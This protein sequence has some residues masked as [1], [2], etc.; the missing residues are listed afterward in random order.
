MPIFMDR[1][2]VHGVTAESVAAAHQEDL[3]VQSEYDCKA[4]TYW[5]DQARGTAFCL[6]E[7]PTAE[8]VKELHRHAHGLVPH[9]I[10]EVKTTE[11]LSFLGRVS[12]PE[13]ASDEPLHEPAFRVIMFTDMANS[14]AITQEL[15]DEAAFELLQ[16]HHQVVRGA[17]AAHRG[18]ELDK[19]GDGFLASFS[20]V[21]S[22]IKCAVAIQQALDTHNMDASDTPIQVRIGL[23]AGEPIADGPALFGSVINQTARICA[24][25]QPGQILVS[26][27]VRDL[28]VGK[29]IAFRPVGQLDIKGFS[30]PVEVE[31]VRWR[32]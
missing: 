30:E 2:D 1:H 14:T 5:F 3:R 12:D 7:A 31:E 10:I 22:A 11:V 18:R 21:G 32:E 6:F 26:R 28:C 25:A 20:S 13:S 15:G 9:D 8:A 16:R 27:V 4:L 24:Q 19:A 29:K 23:G 17:L